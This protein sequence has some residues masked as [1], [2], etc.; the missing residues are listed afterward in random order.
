MH[1][2]AEIT[3]EATNN[4]KAA[5]E[6]IFV[7]NS[8]NLLND[9][10]LDSVAEPNYLSTDDENNCFT[11]CGNVEINSEDCTR[12]LSGFLNEAEY[13]SSTGNSNPDAV[14]ICS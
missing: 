10:F 14:R 9:C 7:S 11:E 2:L 1:I 4:H 13:C 12:N 6:Q 5:N 8:C 3:S